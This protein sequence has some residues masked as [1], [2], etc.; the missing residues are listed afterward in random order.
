MLLCLRVNVK[1]PNSQVI[2]KIF[3]LRIAFITIY[4]EASHVAVFGQNKHGARAGVLSEDLNTVVSSSL[5]TYKLKKK[6]LR[7]GVKEEIT[8]HMYLRQI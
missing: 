2:Q 4:G 8:Y 7:E 6:V 3:V 5:P 1:R